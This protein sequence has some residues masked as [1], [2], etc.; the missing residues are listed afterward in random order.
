MGP[1]SVNF[2]DLAHIYIIHVAVQCFSMAHLAN[3]LVSCGWEEAAENMWLSV[4]M[5]VHF[6]PCLWARL[7][8][9]LFIHLL[10]FLVSWVS[11]LFLG[12][13]PL[14]GHLLGKSATLNQPTE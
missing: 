4:D 8:V 10:I 3:S 12:A 9:L 1:G 5:Y 2:F 14:F 13:L 6:C 11:Y 7:S